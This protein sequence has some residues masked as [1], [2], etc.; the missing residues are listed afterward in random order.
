LRIAL[1]GTTTGALGGS[2]WQKMA[3]GRIAGKPPAFDGD[4]ERR[5]VDLLVEQIGCGA[6]VSAHDLS[7]GGLAMGLV[8]C[9]VGSGQRV[10]AKIGA[11]TLAGD[12][13]V[14]LFAEDGAR[15]LVAVHPDTAEGVA[16]AAARH[17]VPLRWIGE[18]GGHSLH[19]GESISLDLDS[20]A[21]RYEGGMSDAV[22]L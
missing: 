6:L 12:L 17:A 8:R 13:G 18:T 7:I 2:Q 19:L 16:A 22:G 9:C 5:L 21:A 14:A 1:L 4:A 11:E 10:G 15:A 20:L 3:L